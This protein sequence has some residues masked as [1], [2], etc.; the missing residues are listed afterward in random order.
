M[1]SDIAQMLGVPTPASCL[2]PETKVFNN[3]A[4]TSGR[5]GAASFMSEFGSGNDLPD[6]ARVA[7]LAD[8][9]LMSWDYWAYK[10]YGDPTGAPATE[11]LFTS[12]SDLNTVNTSK[13]NLLSRAYPQATAG[14]PQSLS[15]NATTGA[16]SYSYTPRAAS[17]PTQI[18]LPLTRYPHGYSVQVTGGSVIS[19][20]GA[21]QLLVQNNTGATAV[22]INVTAN[23]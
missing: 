20:A 13:V 23:P 8:Q 9:F 2:D 18:Y 4:A 17:A 3:A 12:D 19:P 7:N 14:V 21:A 10:N 11:G 5:M 16:F 1:Q 15:F 22:S 6:I